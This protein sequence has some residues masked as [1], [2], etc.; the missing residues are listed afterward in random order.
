MC[1]TT[2]NMFLGTHDEELSFRLWQPFHV[3]SKGLHV[4]SKG[5]KYTL[6]RKEDQNSMIFCGSAFQ[7]KFGFYQTD[8][9]KDSTTTYSKSYFQQHSSMLILLLVGLFCFL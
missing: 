5:L 2:F 7:G 8:K 4:P 6:G 3:P 9:T 1:R